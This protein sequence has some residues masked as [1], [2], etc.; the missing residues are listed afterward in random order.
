MKR[1]RSRPKPRCPRCGDEYAYTRPLLREDG[2][3]TAYD[4][5]GYICLGND[6]RELEDIRIAERI[7]YEVPE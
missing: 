4:H 5:G 1:R 3:T 2:V 7:L 6:E